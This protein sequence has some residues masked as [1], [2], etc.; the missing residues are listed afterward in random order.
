VGTPVPLPNI[1]GAGS[2]PASMVSG[3]GSGS[4]Y[5]VPSQ[6]DPA[7]IAGGGSAPAPAAPPGSMEAV[8]QEESVLGTLE[9]L[10]S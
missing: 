8:P 3:A 7:Q 1:P 2:L 4:G 9:N 10:F 5:A 6:V